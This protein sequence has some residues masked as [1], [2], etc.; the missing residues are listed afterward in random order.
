MTVKMVVPTLG[1]LVSMW[2]VVM[3]AAGGGVT[4]QNRWDG[5]RVL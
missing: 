5:R 2:G 3:G 1:N 4:S